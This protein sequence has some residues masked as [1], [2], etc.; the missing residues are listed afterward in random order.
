MWSISAI[1]GR[2]LTTFETF[3]KTSSRI[4]TG[5]RLPITWRNHDGTRPKAMM[6]VTKYSASG[7]TQSSGIEAMSVVM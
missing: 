5:A 6:N 7:T 1:A 2:P 4:M 3:T